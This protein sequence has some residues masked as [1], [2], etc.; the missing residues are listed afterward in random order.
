MDGVTD[1]IFFMGPITVSRSQYLGDDYFYVFSTKKC[2]FKVRRGLIVLER[3]QLLF[4]RLFNPKK[5]KAPWTIER[6]VGMLGILTH[7]PDDIVEVE[8]DTNIVKTVTSK[9]LCEKNY[10]VHLHLYLTVQERQD[11]EDAGPQHE[12]TLDY[13]L[14]NIGHTTRGPWIIETLPQLAPNK[15]MIISAKTDGTQSILAPT[16]MEQPEAANW[17]QDHQK[18]RTNEITTKKLKKLDGITVKLKLDIAEAYA[19]HLK[20]KTL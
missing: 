8:H 12:P 5:I 2:L 19:A 4:P 10:K 13:F 15:V 20:Q 9:Y 16:F 18:C 7:A 14:L 1:H 17:F 6:V 3:L 11:G